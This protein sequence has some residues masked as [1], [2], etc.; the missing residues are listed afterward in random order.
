MD[1][2]I[3]SWAMQR[4][5]GVNK[6]TLSNLAKRDIVQRGERKGTYDLEASVGVYCHHLR[7]QAAGRSGEAGVT[8]R[9]YSLASKIGSLAMLLAMRRASSSVSTF[10][11]CAGFSREPRT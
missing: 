1:D 4:L 7:E 6:V 5:L 2:E 11:M 10:A 9:H 8:A 3:T